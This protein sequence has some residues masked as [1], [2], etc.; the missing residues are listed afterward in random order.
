MGRGV[1]GRPPVGGGAVSRRR[2]GLRPPRRGGIGRTPPVPSS[3][4]VALVADAGTRRS[5]VRSGHGGGRPGRWPGALAGHRFDG[6]GPATVVDL[7][8]WRSGG[9]PGRQQGGPT[10]ARVK[11]E[12]SGRKEDDVRLGETNGYKFG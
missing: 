7:Q 5:A 2:R 10:T 6:G 4:K 8:I 12:T 3:A 11:R 1:A 9:A